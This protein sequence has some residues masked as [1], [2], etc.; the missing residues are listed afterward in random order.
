MIPY[1]RYNATHLETGV[2]ST[3]ESSWIGKSFVINYNNSIVKRLCLLIYQ[4][5]LADLIVNLLFFRVFDVSGIFDWHF[6]SRNIGGDHRNE[7]MLD[8][9][10]IS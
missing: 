1:L 7:E 8:H 2:I 6:H 4:S 3:S 10:G 5:E 9:Y